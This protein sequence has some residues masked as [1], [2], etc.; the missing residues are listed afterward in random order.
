MHDERAITAWIRVDDIARV[1]ALA[2]LYGKDR[3]EVLRE[4]IAL[5]LRCVTDGL[6]PLAT[7]LASPATGRMIE[8]APDVPARARVVRLTG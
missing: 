8:V 6:L 3:R 4:L 7:P 5:G 1:D 2:N